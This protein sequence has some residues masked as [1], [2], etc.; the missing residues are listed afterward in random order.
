MEQA[1]VETR[2][3]SITELIANKNI[4][5]G[6]I[7]EAMEK[8]KDYGVIP[9]TKKATLYKPG[10]EKLLMMFKLCAVPEAIENRSTS[11]ETHYLVTTKIVHAP[12]GIV[13]GYGVGEASSDEE[14]YKWRKASCQEEF[15]ETPDDRRRGKWAPVWVKGQKVWD[16]ERKAY[17]MEKLLQVRTAHADLANTILKMADKRSFLGATLKVTAASSVFTQDLE[18]LSA[19]LR[20]VVVDAETVSGPANDPIQQ[21][22]R[23]SEEVNKKTGEIEMDGPSASQAKAQKATTESRTAQTGTQWKLMNSKKPGTCASCGNPIQVG[24]PIFWDGADFE[25]HHKDCVTG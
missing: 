25:A 5:L 11:D 16:K 7:K 23:T 2:N 24:D 21:P 9:G 18:D 20:E 12:S 4:V 10:A 6:A 1:L 17:K 13:V 3:L 14:K 15:D 19:E 8:D 22:E